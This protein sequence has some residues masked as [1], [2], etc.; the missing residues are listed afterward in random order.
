MAWS[1][2]GSGRTSTASHR[3][4]VKAV[5]ARDPDCKLRY[6]HICTG[7]STDAD[8]IVPAYQG[9]TDDPSNGQ[10]ACGPCHRRRS[11]R[12]GHDAQRARG[13]QKRPKRPHPGLIT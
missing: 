10:G 8:H 9:G 13:T 6:P 2:A 11:S 1:S 12:Q 4:F 5:L 3:A 7:V